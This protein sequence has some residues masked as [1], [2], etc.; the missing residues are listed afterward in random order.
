MLDGRKPGFEVLLYNDKNYLALRTLNLLVSI[1]IAV[2][3]VVR[4]LR[5]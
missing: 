4:V 3:Y 5:T 1:E 2:L